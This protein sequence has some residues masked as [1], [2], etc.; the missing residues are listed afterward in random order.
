MCKC[1][2]YRRTAVNLYIRTFYKVLQLLSVNSGTWLCHFY[3]NDLFVLSVM[4]MRGVG[5]LWCFRGKRHHVT[6]AWFTSSCRA[7]ISRRMEPLKVK[8]MLL[9]Y[10]SI[11][12]FLKYISK[13]KAYTVPIY[14]EQGKDIP[15]SQV[16]GGWEQELFQIFLGSC[17]IRIRITFIF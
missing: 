1:T 8:L 7:E 13:K 17:R 3:H 14:N 4:Y 6:Q 5:S 9:L 2:V 16:F 12:H 10:F 11:L 15:K